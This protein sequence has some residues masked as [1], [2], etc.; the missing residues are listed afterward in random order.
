MLSFLLSFG[1]SFSKSFPASSFTIVV[2]TSGASSFCLIFTL[3]LS[4]ELSSIY[5]IFL[6]FSSKV[7]S[8]LTIF[9]ST[10]SSSGFSTSVFSISFTSSDSVFVFIS[11]ISS[12]SVCIFISCIPSDS[13]CVFISCISPD[14]VCVFIS[15]ICSGSV[16]GF[17]PSD[18][19]TS[20]SVISFIP[21][22]CI[23]FLLSAASISFSYSANSSGLSSLLVWVKTSFWMV[24]VLLSERTDIIWLPSGETVFCSETTISKSLF[25]STFLSLFSSSFWPA[26]ILPSVVSSS[27]SFSF[28]VLFSSPFLIS[29]NSSIAFSTPETLLEMFSAFVSETFTS[30]VSSVDTSLTSPFILVSLC[31]ST[32]VS[33][34]I[35]WVFSSSGDSTWY[36]PHTFSSS[37]L[38][39][40]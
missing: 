30:L 35:L 22:V 39:L 13:V 12:D 21:S 4:P 11:F 8:D 34:F 24:S 31:S 16:F 28:R 23:L 36:E 6:T 38:S 27:F 7:L 40:L 29:V 10:T 15:F 20:I 26:I 5:F 1:A 2:T 18:S 17:F 32:I 3:P 19:T 37:L 9:T 25:S 33:T 14:S